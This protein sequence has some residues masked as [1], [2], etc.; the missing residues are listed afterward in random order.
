M[1]Q[2]LLANPTTTILA[3]APSNSAADLLARKLLESNQLRPGQL[4]RLNALS[5]A[6]VGIPNSVLECSFL[7]DGHFKFPSVDVLSSSEVEYNRRV[8]GQNPVRALKDYRVVVSTCVTASVPYQLGLPRGHFDWIFVDEAGQ[9][10]E[11][12][13]MIAVK[14]LAGPDTNLVLS[15][16]VSK[17]SSNTQNIT[18][19]YV[20]AQAIRSY[21]TFPY[22]ITDGI[23]P[24]LSGTTHEYGDV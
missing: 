22:C 4:L 24:E 17:Y 15:G 16:D 20:L 5:R 21:N 23:R 19:L 3:T 8:R 2:L 1:L 11:P 7:S 14:T 13:A 10:C 12:E 6:S 9:A 18:K